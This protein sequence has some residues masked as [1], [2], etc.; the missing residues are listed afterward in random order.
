MK[1]DLLNP[2]ATALDQDAQHNHKKHSGNNP[3]NCRCVHCE[4]PFLLVWRRLAREEHP[5]S[6]K[7]GVLAPLLNLRAAALDQNHQYN[8]KE[9]TR[10]DTNNRRCIHCSFPLSLVAEQ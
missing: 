3:D 6:R 4:S 9:R 5:A 10:D 2:G 8:Y 1:V 7:I